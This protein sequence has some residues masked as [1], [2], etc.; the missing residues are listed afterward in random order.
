VE[1]EAKATEEVAQKAAEEARLAAG[2]KKGAEDARLAEIERAKAA[3]IDKPIGPLAA[4]T[5]PAQPEAA[6]PAASPQVAAADIPKLLQKELRRV[7]C[8]TGAVNGEWDAAAQKSLA[9]FNTN[10]G[11][12]LDVKVASLDALDAVKGRTSRICPLI[13]DHGYKADGE[14]CVKI[15]CGSG[16][17]LND[18]N[19]CERKREKP[20]ATREEAPARREKPTREVQAPP[21]KPQAQ[22]SG[23]VF[24]N[25]QGCRPV[26][27]GCVIAG[28][29]R[30]TNHGGAQREVC[31]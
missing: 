11:T 4:L 3:V 24:C 22:T 30:G 21:A 27:R 6:A 28:G 23:Q 5:P 12:T 20:S 15:T 14:R 1:R 26:A 17:F 25:Q 2:K 18:D 19:E 13:C 10:A 9:S 29:G 16:F 31:F 8:N 7:G